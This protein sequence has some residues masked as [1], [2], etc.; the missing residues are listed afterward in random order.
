MKIAEIF[1]HGGCG[2][3]GHG[4]CDGDS[5][6]HNRRGDYY[7]S[8]DRDHNEEHYDRHRGGGLL[9]ILGGY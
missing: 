6:R 8:S 2:G 7:W 5:E 9:G 3:R 4:G 1:S